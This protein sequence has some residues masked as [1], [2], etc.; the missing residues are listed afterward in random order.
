[1]EYQSFGRSGLITSRICFGGMLLCTDGRGPWRVPAVKDEATSVAMLERYVQAGGNFIDTSNNYGE[2]ETVIGNWIKNKSVHARR[3]LIIC[4]KFRSSVDTI[5]ATAAIN[6][7]NSRGSSRK[8]IMDAIED[9]MEKLQVKYLDVYTIHYWDDAT[10]LEEV[11]RTL[12]SLIQMGR[13]RY[14]AVSNYTPVQLQKL[15]S[16]CEKYQ[17]ELPIFIQ[18]QYNLLSR[19]AEWEMIRLCQSHSI[20]FLAWSPLSGGWLSDKYSIQNS[21]QLTKPPANSRMSFGESVHFSPWDLSTMACNPKTWKVLRVCSEIAAELKSTVSQVAIRWIL[22]QE[23]TGCIIGPRTLNHLE[24]NFA[25]LKLNLTPKHMAALNDASHSPP[26]YPYCGLLDLNIKSPVRVEEIDDSTIPLIITAADHNQGIQHLIDFSSTFKPTTNRAAWMTRLLPQQVYELAANINPH[27]LAV[28]RSCVD[29]DSSSLIRTTTRL[30]FIFGGFVSIDEATAKLHQFYVQMGQN[31]TI[32]SFISDGL[33]LVNQLLSYVKNELKETWIDNNLNLHE[34]LQSGSPTIKLHSD[35]S[36]AVCFSLILINQFVSF[37]YLL[38]SS[39]M[40]LAE[41]KNRCI[42]SSGFSIGLLTAYAVD[43]SMHENQLQHNAL[44]TIRLAFWFGFRATQAFQQWKLSYYATQLIKID[45]NISHPT[46]CTHLD[47]LNYETGSIQISGVPYQSVVDVIDQFNNTNQ[48]NCKFDICVVSQSNR[49]TIGGLPTFLYE[50]VQY[51]RSKFPSSSLVSIPINVPVHAERYFTNTVELIMQ[52]FSTGNPQFIGTPV[53]NKWDQ[54]TFYSYC[55]EKS[56]NSMT[57]SELITTTLVRVCRWDRVSDG[58][59]QTIQSNS[60]ERSDSSVPILML[61]FGPGTRSKDLINN[62]QYIQEQ[63]AQGRIT[64]FTMNNPLLDVLV[65]AQRMHEI[66]IDEFY[67]LGNNASYDSDRINNNIAI[68]GMACRFPESDSVDEVFYNLLHGKNSM[69][70]IP[71]ERWDHSKYYDIESKTP[72]KMRS[73]HMGVIDEI[74]LFDP[75]FFNLNVRDA[76]HMPPEHRLTLEMCYLAVENAGYVIGEGS[77]VGMEE[78]RVGVF[79]GCTG[80]DCYRKN[81][82][83]HLNG[84]VAQCAARSMQAGRVSYFFK[85]CG[86]AI[87]IDTACSTS[88]FCLHLAVESILNGE[89]DVA[90]VSAVLTCIDPMEYAAVAAAGFFGTHAD[91]GCKVFSADADGYTRSE[92]VAAIVI[93][94]YRRALRDRDYVYALINSTAVNQSGQ[95]Q[96]L[97]LPSQPQIESLMRTVLVKARLPPSAIQYIEAHAAGTERGDPIEM[98]AIAQVLGMDA[99][100]SKD[101]PLYVSSHKAFIGHS[102]AAAGLAGLIKTVMMLQHQTITPHIQIDKINRKINM[103]QHVLI[104]Q[105]ACPWGVPH[106]KMSRRAI[107]NSFG[108]SGANAS[109]ILQEAPTRT[110]S[111]EHD[112]LE[113][114]YLITLSGKHPDSLKAYCLRFIQYLV[115]FQTKLATNSSSTSTS[116]TT[117]EQRFLRDLA[118]TTTARRTHFAHRVAIVTSSVRELIRKLVFVIVSVPGQLDKLQ[119]VLGSQYVELLSPLNKN[120]FLSKELQNPDSNTTT[121]AAAIPTRI[122]FVIG[123]QGS[124]YANMCHDLLSFE[125]TWS[126]TFHLCS[127]LFAIL[128]PS[129]L[130]RN[131]TLVQLLKAFHA[132]ES[133]ETDAGENLVLNDQILNSTLVCQPL[134]FAIEYSLG[135]MLMSWGIFPDYIIGHSFGELVGACLASVMTLEDALFLIGHRARLME[136][137]R[138]GAMLAINCNL[139]DFR[140]LCETLNLNRNDQTELT[141][142]AYNGA[143]SIVIGGEIMAIRTLKSYIATKKLFRA[144]ELNVKRAFHT[145]F[146]TPI[147]SEF[148][149]IASKVTYTVSKVPI[150]DNLNGKVRTNFN[151]K[152]WT[153]QLSQSVQFHSAACTLRAFGLKETFKPVCIELSPTPALTQYLIEPGLE[154]E[155]YYIMHKQSNDIE[156]IYSV[157]GQLYVHHMIRVCWCELHCGNRYARVLPL[158]NYAFNYKSCWLKLP[159]V[160]ETSMDETSSNLQTC[161]S[162]TQNIYQ[163]ERITRTEFTQELALIGKCCITDDELKRSSQCSFPIFDRV[164]CVDI[165]NHIVGGRPLFSF[166]LYTALISQF[167]VFIIERGGTKINFKLDVVVKDIIMRK[168]FIWEE[169]D[170]KPEICREMTISL[171]HHE[172]TSENTVVSHKFAFTV[173]SHRRINSQIDASSKPVVHTSGTIYLTNCDLNGI[174]TNKD[175]FNRCIKNLAASYKSKDEC[176]SYDRNE[177]YQMSNKFNTTYGPHY[178][179]MEKFVASKDGLTSWSQQSM[180]ADQPYFDQSGLTL[181]HPSWLDSFMQGAAVQVSLIPNLNRPFVAM[182]VENMICCA[183]VCNNHVIISRNS[184]QHELNVAQPTSMTFY[185]EIRIIIN[186]PNRVTFDISGFDTDGSCVVRLTG[187]IMVSISMGFNTCYGGESSLSQSC[188]L[189]SLTHNGDITPFEPSQVHNVRKG[190]EKYRV[191]V[192]NIILDILSA[193]LE[194]NRS[195]LN[196][197]E[198][199]V[200]MGVD[201]LLSLEMHGLLQK[202][203]HNIALPLTA[204]FD[205]PSVNELTTFIASL[206]TK[207]PQEQRKEEHQHDTNRGLSTILMGDTHE[208]VIHDNAIDIPISNNNK[209]SVDSILSPNEVRN[210]LA[211]V[212]AESLELDSIQIKDDGRFT[213]IGIDLLLSIEIREKIQQSFGLAFPP[214][215]LFDH[216]TLEKLTEFVVNQLFAQIDMRKMIQDKTIDLTNSIDTKQSQSKTN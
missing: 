54:M 20:G 152:Y 56:T 81:M 109:C 47:I 159:W 201:S 193:A 75:Q 167:V 71:K 117:A 110:G 123:G 29:P 88:L 67:L 7:P 136:Q 18:C 69:K 72:Y 207:L 163:S 87:Q 208:F 144:K 135:K 61:D 143:Q 198:N 17:C 45:S 115:A 176:N 112:I 63:L 44:A 107:V 11:I 16:L 119:A 177:F 180:R 73:K 188:N 171:M 26:I 166:P 52:D 129:L 86:P 165:Q 15:I 185:T 41:M 68:I 105:Q 197:N 150:L 157:V 50:L 209:N 145:T 25:A 114:T 200:N 100:R 76:N 99:Y 64:L 118:Y 169:T 160:A 60:S 31:K 158:P 134:L 202:A 155:T 210:V 126:N 120:V 121:I 146:M 83:A 142:S 21:K 9:S 77:R 182:F 98:N 96:N 22:N 79:V 178:Q 80:F 206:N 49:V 195:T 154:I 85:F 127:K 40:T 6:Y 216:P 2:S 90:I 14:Y 104:P 59:A 13:I 70:E 140:S 27:Y 172:N 124:Q 147:L 12:Q 32:Q 65:A 179:S 213:D 214:S 196:P 133:G 190:A 46:E 128:H 149:S 212:M 205:H 92:G 199:F 97:L 108:F 53:K 106:P 204:V 84:Y 55:D 156:Q 101:N 130:P 141:V 170:S 57:L 122:V 153:D 51:L 148:Y 23:V 173:M 151:A 74:D 138:D 28:L 132:H 137:T 42:F 174:D 194:I 33:E 162:S 111:Y 24:D 211:T 203:F 38:Q 35:I 10:E 131:L 189:Q 91:G 66:A 192:Q 48:F 103:Q 161:N 113:L 58:L 37:M 1:M 89:C 5:Q 8:H 181:I 3:K 183:H 116:V 39:N 184:N 164:W 94:P 30:V 62:N 36:L 34:W 139:D 4:T 125:N 82:E 175:S 78:Q 93:K 186:D 102:E 191:T 168:P 43:I 215:L 187:G 19:V 95:S